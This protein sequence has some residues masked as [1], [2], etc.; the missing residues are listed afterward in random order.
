MV[1][2]EAF[3]AGTPVVASDIAGYRD[4]VTDGVDG[5]L[6]PR[7]DAT[8]LAE[9]LRDLALDPARIDATGRRRGRERR[10]LRVAA[11]RRAGRRRP[12]RTRRRCPSPRARSR[13]RRCKVGALPADGLPRV[14]ARR[15]PSLEPAP[16]GGRRR[17][18][19]R[20]LLGGAAAWRRGRGFGRRG[21][22]HR[23][24]P[25]R[26]RAGAL[27]ARRGCWSALALMCAVDAAARGLL[28][29][30]P[31]GGAAGGAAADGRRR[32]GDDDRRADVAR[33]CPRASA[34]RRARWSSRGGWAVRATDCRS[35]SARSSRRR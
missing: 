12:T 17:G 9:T 21:R 20:G 35:C 25:D 34:S 18:S 14:P 4:V 27:R 8:A 29:R 7:G 22:A 2:T 5:L 30:D 24:G 33:R 3:A 15:L 1:L 16:D 13:A 32:P 11:G 10:A 28:A 6:V 23:A 19:R 26:R 31:E